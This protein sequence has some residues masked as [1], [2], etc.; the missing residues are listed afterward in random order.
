MRHCDRSSYVREL[1]AVAAIDISVVG[2]AAA[3]ALVADSIA[4]VDAVGIAAL[5]G[6]LISAGLEDL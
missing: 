3:D 4:A 1:A 6:D 5:A 2:I